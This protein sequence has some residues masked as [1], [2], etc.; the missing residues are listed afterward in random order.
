MQSKVVA[1][2][3]FGD[4]FR[5]TQDA[6]PLDNAADTIAFCNTGDPV[7]QNGA[8]VLAH[9]QYATDG[10]VGKAAT[11]IAGKFTA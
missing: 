1:V 10:S 11:F 9:L 7:C 3:V 5:L 8:N 4:P 6:F 2:A